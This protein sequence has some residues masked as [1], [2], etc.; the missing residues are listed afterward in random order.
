MKRFLLPFLVPVLV[1]ATLAVAHAGVTAESFS[2]SPFVGG[3]SFLGREHLKTRPVGGVRGG[4]NF[5]KHVGAEA[6]FDFTRTE[7]RYSETDFNVYDYHFDMLYHFLP[8][9]PLVPFLAAGYGGQTRYSAYEGS[10]THGVFNYGGG[11]KL[12]LTDKM[13]LRGDVRHLIQKHDEHSYHDLQYTVGLDFLF[14]GVKPAAAAQARPPQAL[15]EQPAP[16]PAPAEVPPPVIPAEP[17]RGHF[18]Y[19]VT[20]HGEFDIDRALIRPEYREEIALVGDFM[21]KYP[22]T[23]AVI[24]GHTDNVGD[25]DYNLKLS[26]RRAE[27]VVNYLVDNYGI[28]RSRLTAKGYGLTRPV[29]DNA[30]DAGRQKN[31]RVEAVIDCAFDATK[32]EPP[33]R[34]CM[35]LVLDFESGSAQIRAEDRSEI[36]KVADF[37]KRYPTTTA[38]IEGHTDNEGTPEGNMKLSQERAQ[39]VVDYLVQNFGIEQ[40]RLAAK[41]YGATRRIAYNATPE[42]RAKNRRINAVIDCVVR[43]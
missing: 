37:M 6:A 8:D 36:A 12:F 25:A 3:Y 19:C 10:V 41:G 29:A 13:A 21:K 34:L 39:A 22:D 15:P 23:T 38:L 30:T 9:G 2:V 27:A 7:A 20:L 26:Q 35:G 31:R 1:F 32:V 33:E 14:G 42:G 5:T 18:T 28:D 17:Q 24:E 11:M 40:N 4:Y 43:K 16:A